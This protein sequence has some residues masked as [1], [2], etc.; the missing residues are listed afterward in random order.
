MFI[1]ME[2]FATK[3]TNI[4]VYQ[5]RHYW[6]YHFPLHVVQYNSHNY[7]FQYG[8]IYISGYFAKLQC[9][10]IPYRKQKKLD[11]KANIFQINTEFNFEITSFSNYIDQAA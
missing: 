9:P 11:G 6:L 1:E 10:S 2:G 4:L 8:S 7:L 3:K 5:F